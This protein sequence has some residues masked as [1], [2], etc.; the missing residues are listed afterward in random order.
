MNWPLFI[1]GALLVG[2]TVGVLG[3]GGSL[4]TLPIL[5][6]LLKHDPE[7]AIGESMLIVGL[8]ALAASI[9]YAWNR[10]IAWPYVLMF[11]IGGLVGALL[12]VELGRHVGGSV[13]LLILAVILL[14]AATMMFLK[15]NKA[16]PPELEKIAAQKLLEQ[17]ASEL[18]PLTPG[19]VAVLLAQGLGIGVLTGLVGVGGGFLIVPALV[20]AGGLGMHLAVGTSIVIIFLNSAVGFARFYSTFPADGSTINWNA[21]LLFGLVGAFGSLFGGEVAKRL[22][23]AVLQRIFA[24]L[25][26]VLGIW[27][28]ISEW[29]KLS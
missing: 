26:V 10:R 25:L 8:I 14:L 5:V 12:G 29:G 22:P 20:L 11:G 23:Q 1:I 17:S 3:S 9:P 24:I 16:P 7:I 6:Y 13:Q 2:L 4:L 21:V 28:G 19:R 18:P 15:G 27:I